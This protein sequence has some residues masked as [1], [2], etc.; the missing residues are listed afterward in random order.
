MSTA[1]TLRSLVLGGLLASALAACGGSGSDPV[2]SS[3]GSSGGAA[4]AFLLPTPS[5]DAFY[6]QPST[7]PD[8]PPGTI[9]NSRAVSY[10]PALSV[11]LPNQ[12][13]QLQYISQDS[14]G[15]P[16]AAIATVVKPLL[17]ALSQPAPLVSFQFAEDS[18]G[19][20][21]SP[22]QTLQGG[23]ANTV[24]QAE[25]LEYI[26]GLETQGWT[27][28]FPDHEGPYSEYA[29]GALAGHI[30]LD[31]IRAAK[32]FAALGLNSATPVG[33]WGY[34]G[35]ALATAWAATLQPTYAPEL[36][37]AAVA[38]GGTP[39]DV[40]SA[41]KA[42]DG[43]GTYGAI[44]NLLFS[45][46]L[47]AVIGVDRAYPDMVPPAEFNARGLAAVATLRDTCQ[48]NPTDG[49]LPPSG[50]F[51][52]YVDTGGSDVFS[53]PG[54]LETAPKITL[55]QPGR[56][57]TAKSIFVYHSIIDE[58]IP[59]AGT[60][61]M[62]QTWCGGGS[63]VGYYRALEGEHIGLDATMAPFAL[64]YFISVFNGLAPVYPPG[65]VS[66]N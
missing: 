37:L 41:A 19:L 59:I 18:L 2:A 42:F 40:I 26:A 53:T 64:A 6:A 11:P 39:A 35:G 21:C 65:A 4:A 20:K 58:L 43:Q 25:T 27:M 61:A 48:G 47:S 51:S 32:N 52:D 15:K 33:L 23:T 60:D 14:K 22:S 62:V 44:A 13:W 1:K 16:I 55:P 38:S 5:A 17:P 3:G 24:S 57:P 49:S 30:T 36:N 29:A 56:T 7:M 45:L 10:A 50:H 63:H 31:G 66:C 46:G 54:V 9:L 28:V 12:A 8:A 34:S